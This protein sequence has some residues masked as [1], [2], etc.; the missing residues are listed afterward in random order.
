MSSLHNF[1]LLLIC[2]KVS[3]NFRMNSTVMTASVS[4]ELRATF[5]YQNLIHSFLSPRGSFVPNL[6]KFTQS[7]P[8]SREWDEQM[9][10]RT[11]PQPPIRSA[12]GAVQKISRK[13]RNDKGPGTD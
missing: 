9:E 12:A 13:Q 10:R 11:T 1:I 6:K 3:H 8:D 5:N 2:Q 7:S 4:C